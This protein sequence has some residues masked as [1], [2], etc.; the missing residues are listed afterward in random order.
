MSE[1]EGGPGNVLGTRSPAKLESGMSEEEEGGGSCTLK[2]EMSDEETSTSFP[3]LSR[4]N[5][6]LPQPLPPP[7]PLAPRR[8]RRLEN[9]PHSE[10]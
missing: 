3:P 6:A 2:Q 7:A 10:N 4:V 1:E 9:L 8:A 5:L